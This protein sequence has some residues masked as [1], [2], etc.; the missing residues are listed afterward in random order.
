MTDVR[1][2]CL[3]EPDLEF[4]R[5]LTGPEPKRVLKTAGPFD[6][7]ESPEI[8]RIGLV[9][10]AG[11]VEAAKGWLQRL[12]GMLVSTEGNSRRFRDYPGALRAFSA[13]FDLD[14]RFIRPLDE[15]R[16]QFAL[17]RRLAK[18]RFDAMIELYE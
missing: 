10:P 2:E 1:I 18:D 5:G 13:R 11:E 15:D 14:T 7:Q 9:G 8:I 12:N 17:G 16:F 6:R 4:G 3:R